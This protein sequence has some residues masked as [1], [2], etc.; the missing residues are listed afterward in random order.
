MLNA[1][2]AQHAAEAHCNCTTMLVK[3][4]SSPGSAAQYCCIT[5]TYAC[6][7]SN[8]N[9]QGMTNFARND[10]AS[11]LLSPAIGLKPSPLAHLLC[12]LPWKV[13]RAGHL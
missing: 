13:L 7:P 11:A 5:A 6:R 4:G 10:T 2:P 12:V 8:C 3:V 9:C 1:A